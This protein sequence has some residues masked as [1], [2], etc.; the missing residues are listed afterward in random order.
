MELLS[1]EKSFVALCATEADR[2]AW[3]ADIAEWA[4]AAAGNNNNI[5]ASMAAGGGGEG[6]P[7]KTSAFRSNDRDVE[8]P[9]NEIQAVEVVGTEERTELNE[10]TGK[11]AKQWT[12]YVFRVTTYG[13]SSWQLD[14]RYSAVLDFHKNACK[15]T[16]SDAVNNFPFP[17]KTIFTGGKKLISQRCSAFQLYFRL[18]LELEERPTPLADFLAPPGDGSG[19]TQQQVPPPPPPPPKPTGGSDPFSASARALAAG[20]VSTTNPDPP[21]PPPPPKPLKPAALDQTNAPTPVAPAPTPV[22]PSRAP[23]VAPSRPPPTP[24]GRA[25]PTPP[26]T[27]TAGAGAA[28]PSRPPPRPPPLPPSSPAAAGA[29]SQSGANEDDLFMQ[30]CVPLNA[31]CLCLSLPL[32]CLSSFF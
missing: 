24:P 6:T 1:N 23:P 8:R 5:R 22:A 31:F 10:K 27:T 16:A 18:L 28:P 13:G 7:S 26:T 11:V 32:S 4:A 29:A 17:E 12:V 15:K 20:T 3:L 19:I 2:D 30:G 25:P 21:P 14:Q 9:P